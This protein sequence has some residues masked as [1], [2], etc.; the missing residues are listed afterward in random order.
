[1]RFISLH[2]ILRIL[3]VVPHVI[4][5]SIPSC[6]SIIEGKVS[7]NAIFPSFFFLFLFLGGR[8]YSIN[9]FLPRIKVLALRQFEVLM[10][11]NRVHL[12]LPFT[13]NL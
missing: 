1:M 3:I 10:C 5:F 6:E 9:R 2:F 7:T 11:Q 4:T 12:A 13:T 8:G